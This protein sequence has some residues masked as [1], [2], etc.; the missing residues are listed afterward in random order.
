MLHEERKTKLIEFMDGQTK[1]IDLKMRLWM[2]DTFG[3][4][5]YDELAEFEAELTGEQRKTFLWIAFTCLS[6]ESAMA[7]LT[8][9]THKRRLNAAW[10]ETYDE[11]IEAA[12]AETDEAD[13]KFGRMRKAR[14]NIIRR[15]RRLKDKVRDSDE[16]LGEAIARNIRLQSKVQ[17]LR[18]ELEQTTGFLV[19]A[20]VEQAQY[21]DLKSAVKKLMA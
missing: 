17:G 8:Q 20:E 4:A 10:I 18:E 19:A 9:T 12:K 2:Q 3:R 13:K 11:A 6:A 21:R 14:H 16:A 15:V 1:V 5:T 7:V